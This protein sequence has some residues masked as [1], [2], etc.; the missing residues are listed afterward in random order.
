MSLLSPAALLEG[1][2]GD[3]QGIYQSAAAQK[4]EGKLYLFLLL[5]LFL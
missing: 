4:K 5:L 1:G 3:Y 2:E